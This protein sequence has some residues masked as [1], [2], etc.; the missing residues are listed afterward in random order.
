[1]GPFVAVADVTGLLSSAGTF[2]Y[3]WWIAPTPVY[4]APS[5]GMALLGA[6]FAWLMTSTALLAAYAIGHAARRQQVR[7]TDRLVAGLPAGM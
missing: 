5:L 6:A 7:Q 1:M 4:P 3:I 2:V